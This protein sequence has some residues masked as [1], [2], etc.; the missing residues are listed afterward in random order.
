MIDFE[1]LKIEN[2]T[3]YEKIQDRDDNIIK[4][5]R[6]KTYNIQILT[7]LREKLFF[8]ITTNSQN[9]DLLQSWEDKVTRLRSLVSLSRHDQD[10]N[11]ND[12]KIEIEARNKFASNTQLIVDYNTR[13]ETIN[14]LRLKLGQ[15][16]ERHDTLKK[17]IQRKIKDNNKNTDTQYNSSTTKQTLHNNNSIYNNTMNTSGINNSMSIVYP[18]LQPHTTAR[19]M[20]ARP[21]KGTR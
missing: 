19:P 1:Q 18:S 11:N 5:K 12:N 8:L 17:A 2:Q 4:L 13:F 9:Y 6:K 16:R 21:K 15:V 10:N 7:H 14:E 20:V 3:Y